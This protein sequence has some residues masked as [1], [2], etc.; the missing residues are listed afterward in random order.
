M[1]NFLNNH[2]KVDKVICYDYVVSI[3]YC[4]PLDGGFS[5]SQHREDTLE[6]PALLVHQ[7]LVRR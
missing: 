3:K 6:K 5:D 1:E 7:A 4:I 2:L